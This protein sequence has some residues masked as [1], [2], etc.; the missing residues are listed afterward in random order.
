M[1]F[2]LPAIHIRLM[3]PELFLFIWALVI[4][5]FDVI[6]RLKNSDT[7]GYLAMFG[8]VVSS[9]LLA[10]TGYGE[11]F[12]RMFHNDPM[13]LLF[14]IIFLGAAF[15]TIG[16]SFGVLRD[17]IVN[18]RGEFLGLILFSTVGMMFL[19][20]SS[21]LLSLYIGLELTT[22]PLFVLAGFFKDD[23]KSVEAG[24]KY[25]VVGAFSS[26]LLLYGISFLYGMTGTTDILQMRLALAGK[27]LAGMNPNYA[28][29]PLILIV[30]TICVLA[31]IGFKLALP[32]FLEE[33]R[34]QIE[35]GLKPIRVVRS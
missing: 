13:A 30:A 9:C 7:V 3:L 23:K 8:V 14:K 6:T 21:E 20:S 16:S 1:D 34:A 11:G 2:Q 32:P 15:M 19:S 35:A 25:L 18:H 24:I 31:G 17:K 27:A 29:D 33:Q 4:I 28:Q 12:G 26:A 10:V 5:I 22:V